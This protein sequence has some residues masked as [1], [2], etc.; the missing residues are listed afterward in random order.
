MAFTHES[1]KTLFIFS[2]VDTFVFVYKW[3]KVFG[4]DNLSLKDFIVSKNGSVNRLIEIKVGC[5]ISKLTPIKICMQNE[6]FFIFFL[7]LTII[8][9]HLVNSQ[10]FM[11]CGLV[12]MNERF[13]IIGQKK[14]LKEEKSH[15]KC[16]HVTLQCWKNVVDCRFLV[17]ATE[18]RNEGILL[19]WGEV[20]FFS[21]TNEDFIGT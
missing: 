2:V 1:E 13:N 3:Q 7:L 10:I 18:R 19:F 20:S 11:W 14:F 5:K 21:K 12:T 6:S 15:P 16:F 8:K 4:K 17:I 9:I